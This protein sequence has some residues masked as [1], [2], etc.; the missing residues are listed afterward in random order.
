MAIIIAENPFYPAEPDLV[1]HAV[2][3]RAFQKTFGEGI[4]EENE[5]EI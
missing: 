5:V 2:R 4:G 1:S 3:G